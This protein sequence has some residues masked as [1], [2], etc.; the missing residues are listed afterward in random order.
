MAFGGF[1]P[2]TV[3]RLLT[4]RY[5]RNANMLRVSK[6]FYGLLD[7]GMARRISRFA[8]HGGFV[9]RSPFAKIVSLRSSVAQR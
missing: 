7:T 8:S 3:A 5:R 2:R 4:A 9:I 1:L 6:A